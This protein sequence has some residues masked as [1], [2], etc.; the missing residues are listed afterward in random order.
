MRKDVAF[1]SGET[2][3]TYA[4]WRQADTSEVN[5]EGIREI[6]IRNGEMSVRTREQVSGTQ[7][8]YRANGGAVALMMELMY[9]MRCCPMTYHYPRTAARK[10]EEVWPGSANT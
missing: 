9:F 7:S 3:L 8:G 5:S 6:R 1:F 4:H 10:D 2:Y